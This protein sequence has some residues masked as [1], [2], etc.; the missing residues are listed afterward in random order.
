MADL[1]FSNKDIPD[2]IADHCY[3]L[4]QES[5]NNILKHADATK[6]SVSMSACTDDSSSVTISIQDNG[7][8]Y[9]GSANESGLGLIGMRERV[10]LLDG[11]FTMTSDSVDG[12]RIEVDLPI[13]SGHTEEGPT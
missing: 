11:E 10:D 12:T 1:R 13:N 6:V 4:L 8:G 9:E 5:L 2:H 3:R 7:C